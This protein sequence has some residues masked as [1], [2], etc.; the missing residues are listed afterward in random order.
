MSIAKCYPALVDETF[1]LVLYFLTQ[2]VKRLF[3]TSIAEDNS[4]VESGM[5]LWIAS[6]GVSALKF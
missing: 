1:G 2:R 5:S 4:K 6:S 3:S